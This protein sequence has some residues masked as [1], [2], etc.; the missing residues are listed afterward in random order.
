MSL[1]PGNSHYF[2]RCRSIC[3]GEAPKVPNWGSRK[4]FWRIL[5]AVDKVKDNVIMRSYVRSVSEQN[6]PCVPSDGCMPDHYG[7]HAAHIQPK[8]YHEQLNWK[9]KGIVFDADN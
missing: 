7:E 8:E 3:P 2:W 5:K 4:G 9:V 6:V 1:A